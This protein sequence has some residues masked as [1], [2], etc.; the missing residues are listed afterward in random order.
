MITAFFL[1]NYIIHSCQNC[2]VKTA[3]F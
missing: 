1:Q 2:F 3:G